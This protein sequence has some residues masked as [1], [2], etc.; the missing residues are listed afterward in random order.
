MET[1]QRLP[2]VEL[3]KTGRRVTRAGLGG[4]GVLRTRGREAAAAEVIEAAIDSGITYYDSARAYQ[5]SEVYHGSVWGRR[6]ADRERIFLTSKSPQRDARGAR[7][8]LEETL[9]RLQVDHLDLWQ[10]HDLRE[11]AEIDE[12]AAPGGALEAFV[13]AKQ[14]G[15][16]RHIGVTGHHSPRVLT[17]AVEAF[18]VDTVLMPANPV[19]G[20]IG[21]FLTQT[22]PAA[23]AKGLGVIGMK[24]LGGAREEGGAGGGGYVRAGLP[25]ETLLRYAFSQAIDVVIVGCATPEEVQALVTASRAPALDAAAQRA[26]VEQ[27]RPDAPQ[28]AYYRGEV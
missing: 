28:L 24:A 22:L 12:L 4:E 15:L 3:G 6:P 1:T 19:E 8:D 18:P 20:A 9:K 23:R 5:D 16:V 10:I 25:A 26:L 14:D 17:R 11:D 7:R 2:D 27:I 21:G 13:K